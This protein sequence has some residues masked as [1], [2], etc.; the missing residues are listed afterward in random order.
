LLRERGQF[1][2]LRAQTA[3]PPVNQKVALLPLNE[4]RIHEARSV[5]FKIRYF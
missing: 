3:R 4:S 1:P 5:I 2:T